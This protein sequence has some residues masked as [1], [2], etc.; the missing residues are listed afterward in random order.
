MEEHAIDI[1]PVVWTGSSLKIIDQTKLPSTYQILTLTDYKEVILA[2]KKLRVRGAPAI[3]IAGACAVALAAQQLAH[4]TREE[5][6]NCAL[7]CSSK[8]FDVFMQKLSGIANQII[9]S[10]P[11][12]INLRW[13]VSRMLAAAYKSDSIVHSS[14]ALS[15]EASRILKEDIDANTSLSTFGSK[16][17]SN[18]DTILTHCNAGALA[19][20]GYGTALGVIK[21][22]W[23]SGKTISV[24]VTETR[25]V[26]QGARLTAWELDQMGVPY[27]LIVDSAAASLMYADGISCVVVGADRISA[28][29]DVVNKIG[30]YSLAIA[31]KA[32]KVPFYIAA[33]TSTVDL[34]IANGKDIPIEERASSEIT[35]I[36]GDRLPLPRLKVQNFAF[37]ITPNQLITAIITE[38]GILKAPYNT[39]LGKVMN[40]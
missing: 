30:T 14:V 33:P 8:P 22:A 31:A 28:N 4:D 3:G 25:P 34:T 16:L 35:D 40:L 7:T 27:T 15:K 6:H 24:I 17:I 18:N 29:G 13:A 39:T 26:L 5:K 12:A 10:R 37:D 9:A 38:K 19:T 23:L 20:G 11:T 2:I 1:R 21:S 36:L 32:N